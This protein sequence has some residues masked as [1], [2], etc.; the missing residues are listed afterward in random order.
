MKHF[1][2]I[3]HIFM[4]SDTKYVLTINQVSSFGQHSKTPTQVL[5]WRGIPN[6]HLRRA[7]L[8]K[9]STGEHHMAI[10]KSTSHITAL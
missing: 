3:E 1:S 9:S 10:W 5:V 8:F 7:Y 4:N 6:F 2:N